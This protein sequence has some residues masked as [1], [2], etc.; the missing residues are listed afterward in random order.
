[1]F[2]RE[3]KN[4]RVAVHGYDFAVLGA[5]KSLDRFMEAIQHKIEVKFKGMLGSG[6][7]RAARILSRVVTVTEKG[8]EHGADQRRAEIMAK[9]LGLSEERESG[10]ARREREGGG[11]RE[12]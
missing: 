4:V 11:A 3:Q 8:L 6:K 7:T 10:D 1:M 9:D 2:Y 12:R 5:E